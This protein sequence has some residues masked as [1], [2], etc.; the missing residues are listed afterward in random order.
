MAWKQRFGYCGGFSNLVEI[1]EMKN[2]ARKFTDSC[3]ELVVC[4]QDIDLQPHCQGIDTPP[5]RYVM[6]DLDVVGR[7]INYTLNG[8]SFIGCAGGLHG[9]VAIQL[10]LYLQI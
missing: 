8:L 2:K 1:D 5:C 10:S 7:A 6:L 9:R 4:C 3:L